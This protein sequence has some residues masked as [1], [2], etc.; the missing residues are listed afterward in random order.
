MRRVVL[1]M[2]TAMSMMTMVTMAQESSPADVGRVPVDT[3]ADLVARPETDRKEAYV[4]GVIDGATVLAND[5]AFTI[6]NKFNMGCQDNSRFTKAEVAEQVITEIT[7]NK[8]LQNQT[9]VFSVLNA[10]EKLYCPAKLILE[11]KK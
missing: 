3:G 4:I 11:G 2:F 1:I 10:Y 6:D 9:E 8:E 7:N 5:G